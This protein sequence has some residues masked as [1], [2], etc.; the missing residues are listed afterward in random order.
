MSIQEVIPVPTLKPVHTLN[1][2]VV[3]NLQQAQPAR[4][5]IMEKLISTASLFHINNLTNRYT[6]ICDFYS[7]RSQASVSSPV[8]IGFATQKIVTPTPRS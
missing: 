2:T 1:Q 7:Q 6:I 4:P 8:Q 3:P 5:L